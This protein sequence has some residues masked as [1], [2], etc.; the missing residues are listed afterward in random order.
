MPPPRPICIP[1][2]YFSNSCSLS[3][4]PCFSTYAPNVGPNKYIDWRCRGYNIKHHLSLFAN[5]TC[6][7]LWLSWSRPLPTLRYDQPLRLATI[8]RTAAEI[9]AAVREAIWRGWRHIL[10]TQCTCMYACMY[11][12]FA[13]G[14]LGVTKRGRDNHHHS[15]EG[16]TYSWL[17]DIV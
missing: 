8:Y 15:S 13:L 2:I 16:M 5:C 17:Y 10:Y 9:Y 6:H 3:S 12:G 14:N 7:E 11:K 4:K 1:F